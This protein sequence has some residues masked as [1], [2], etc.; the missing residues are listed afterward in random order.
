MTVDG[1]PSAFTFYL[2]T[3]TRGALEF[4]DVLAV[5][6]ADGRQPAHADLVTLV[7]AEDQVATQAQSSTANSG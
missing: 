1:A 6:V 2:L 7:T 4:E 3:F 5:P